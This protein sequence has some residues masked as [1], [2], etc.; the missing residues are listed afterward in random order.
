MS[1]SC[2]RASMVGLGVAFLLALA[3]AGR[4]DGA[5]T[6]SSGRYRYRIAPIIDLWLRTPRLRRRVP[7]PLTAAQRAQLRAPVLLRFRV[8][9]SPAVVA[10]LA[11][12]GVRLKRSSLGDGWRHLELF[13]PASTTR[14][15][16]RALAREPVVAQVD[17]DRAPTKPVR[18]LDLTA[19]EVQASAAWRSASSPAGLPLTGKG[20]T[21]GSIDSGVDVYHPAFFRADGGLFGWI[22]VDGNGRFDPG[23]DAV[24]LNGDGKADAGETLGLLEARV[25][26]ITHQTTILDSRNGRFD[27]KSDWLYAD[28]NDNGKRDFGPAA[29]FDDTT[30]TFGERLFVAEDANGNG[31]L[32]TAEKLRALG[33]SKIAYT[34]ASGIARARGGDLSQTPNSFDGHHGTC[35][36]GIMIAGQRGYLSRV[37]LAP[38]ADLVMAVNTFDVS[39][40]ADPGG[41]SD[42]LIWL[43]KERK[44]DVVLHEYSHWINRFLDGSSSHEQLLDQA[45][46]MGI[47]QVVPAGNLAASG[48]KHARVQ[49]APGATGTLPFTVP[50]S[51]KV[52]SYDAAYVTTLWR[53]PQADLVFE[54]TDPFGTKKTLSTANL[55]GDSWVSGESFYYSWRRDSPRG[56]AM[57][58]LW[59][60][61]GDAKTAKP[62]MSG[63]WT[64]RVTNPS[65]QAVELWAYIGDNVT[66]WGPGVGF[67]AHT[68]SNGTICWPATADTA[69]TV[70][71]YAVHDGKPYYQHNEYTEKS[72]GL[73][74]YASHGKR[75]DGTSIM[76]IAAPDNPVTT[77]N[78]IAY[79]DGVYHGL[80]EYVVFSGTSA[81]GP[82]VA[83]GLALL[84]EKEPSLTFA[85]L[86]ARLRTSALADADVGSVP[87]DSWG[88]GK[89]RVYTM[90]FGEDPPVSTPP[91]VTIEGPTN[92]YQGDKVSLRAVVGDAE[93]PADALRVRWDVGYTDAWGSWGPAKTNTI[94]EPAGAVGTDVWVK[95]QVE[96]S[97]GLRATAV[98]RRTV[99]P[100]SERPD[101]GPGP[102][103]SGNGGCAIAA[104]N[105]APPPLVAVVLGVMLFAL[106]SRRRRRFRSARGHRLAGQ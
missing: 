105:T 65:G 18:P 14:A 100:T 87:S 59:L 57:F 102:T 20:V 85:E 66:T 45:S 71:A 10:R 46:A 86:K 44:V 42:L 21:I 73:R 80:G 31:Q 27:A 3:L 36:S 84:A 19:M 96:D 49:L 92:V 32:D 12:A 95:V 55:Q 11:E 88:M 89:L 103:G 76:D 99:Q 13:Y 17:L 4:A 83:A 22:D 24:D 8:P 51:D 16:L 61:G 91:T 82:H 34:Y 33:S 37:G 93:D 26:D 70:G 68:Q 78:R 54:L 52:V 41:T 25:T 28:A 98:W 106:A 77:I 6:P 90:L 40:S 81:A 101:A 50:V 2:T 79:G 29:G 43:V 39:N 7:R 63:Q 53:T 23:K 69:I 62:L 5:P 75:I 30:P 97:S 15:G 58:N 35:T 48:D 94:E 47:P 74:A 72:G 9:P 67:S 38:D 1:R 64:V 56:T 60:G 104:G